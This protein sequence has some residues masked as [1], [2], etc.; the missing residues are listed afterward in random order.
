VSA[1]IEN[2]VLNRIQYFLDFNHWSLYK[3]AKAS[4]LPYSSL[5]NLF[6]RKTCPTIATLEKIC[7][8]FHI[9]L[10]EFFDFQENPLRDKNISDEE[11]DLLNTYAS[12]SVKDK[13]LLQAYLQGLC[14][15]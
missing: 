4:G 5:N 1:L 12:L 8:G 7:L 6:H 14:K 9:T 15:K 13:E 10:S 2:D 11:Q 3:L